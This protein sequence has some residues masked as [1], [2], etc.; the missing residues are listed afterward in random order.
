MGKIAVGPADYLPETLQSLAHPGALLVSLDRRGRPNA[1]TIGW[2]SLGVFWGEP[3]FIVPVRQSR[4][5]YGCINATGDFTVNLLPRKLADIAS[6]C[7]TVSGRDHDKLAEASLT[8]RKGLEVKS[9]IIEEC[10]LNYECRVV[11]V[12]DL[13]PKTLADELMG[14]SYPRGDYHRFFFGQIV[15]VRAEENLRRRL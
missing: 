12:S 3:I 6:F 14:K 2:G 15:A 1:M 8:A 13:A 4:Y 10:V 7:G 9:P 5:T 11:H